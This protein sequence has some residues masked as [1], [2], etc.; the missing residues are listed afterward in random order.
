LY[1]NENT[2]S[3][4]DHEGPHHHTSPTH[5]PHQRDGYGLTGEYCAVIYSIRLK[6]IPIDAYFSLSSLYFVIEQ[7]HHGQYG[8]GYGNG[9]QGREYGY[10]NARQ[11]H[12]IGYGEGGFRS[13]GGGHDQGNVGYYG[14]GAHH[15]TVGHAYPAYRGYG[16]GQGGFGGGVYGGG[17]GGFQ[18]GDYRG[19]QGGFEG[20]YVGNGGLG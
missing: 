17:Q 8:Q 4:Y 13:V 16:G 1:F 5:Y 6:Q 18:G 3:G 14:N 2:Q 15:Q 20:G 7:A 10:G 9:A 19:G 12:G 11:G